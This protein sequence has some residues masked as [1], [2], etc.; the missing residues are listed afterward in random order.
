MKYIELSMTLQATNDAIT[1]E[2]VAEGARE[3]IHD[4]W[5]HVR[6][7]SMDSAFGTSPKPTHRALSIFDAALQ[8]ASANVRK[9]GFYPNADSQSQA[10]V[11]LATSMYDAI[12]YN[13]EALKQGESCSF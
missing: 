5:P 6:V 10:A 9:E 12:F 11:D 8:L 2:Q 3:L 7:A 1:A 4:N 13:S